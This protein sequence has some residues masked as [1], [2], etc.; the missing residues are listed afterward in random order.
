M[1]SNDRNKYRVKLEEHFINK[2]E[3]EDKMALVGFSSSAS[4]YQ[5]LT[6]DKKALLDNV[7]RLGGHSGGTNISA[8]VDSAIQQ[9]KNS[10]DR[11][12]KIILFNLL[13]QWEI[14]ES[15]DSTPIESTYYDSGFGAIAL[16]H[17]ENIIIAFEG[18]GFPLGPELLPDWIETDLGAIGLGL[19][20]KQVYFAYKFVHKVMS[21]EAMTSSTNIYISGHSLGGWLA[22]K[23]GGSLLNGDI[24]LTKKSSYGRE[25]YKNNQI[26]FGFKG[27]VENFYNE[28][29]KRN[30]GQIKKIATFAAPGFTGGTRI[31][32]NH[33]QKSK[34]VYN[35]KMNEDWINQ[36]GIKSQLLGRN[37]WMI[38]GI[39]SPFKAHSI[40]S[41]YENFNRFFSSSTFEK[42][43]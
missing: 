13:N 5:A 6:S 33:A 21:S 22:Q 8:G 24:N 16:K 12:K 4:V 9:L 37:K 40:D 31:Y 25:Y 7:H 17:G 29:F 3:D 26:P 1:S 18:S 23:I 20:S 14:I 28:S 19:N 32:D 41:Y 2:K 10:K 43:E 30:E 35:Y 11:N 15:D 42:N 27:K 34:I 38:S 36:F 39:G